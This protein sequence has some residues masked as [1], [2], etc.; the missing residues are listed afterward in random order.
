MKTLTDQLA[1]YGAY[2]RDPRNIATHIIGVPMI[3]LAVVVLLS[4]PAFDLG[5]TVA[6]PALLAALAAIFFYSRLDFAFGLVMALLIAVML[7][8][9]QWLAI[10][11]T[12]VWLVSGIGL[13]VV[14]W[15]I[16]FVGHWFEGRKPAFV[17]DLVGLLVGPL[18]VVAEIGFVMGM[19]REVQAEVEA[20]IG[21]VRRRGTGGAASPS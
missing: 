21:P 12:G 7:A 11:P 20:R 6:S 15:L 9:G 3:M 2:H 17:D 16:Q 5:P 19:R 10:Q 8:V 1:Q 18:F 14:G 4:R 13:F